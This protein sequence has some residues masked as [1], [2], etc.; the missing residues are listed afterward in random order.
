MFDDCH[1][2]YFACGYNDRGYFRV[3]FRPLFKIFLDV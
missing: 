2:D 3:A 1:D